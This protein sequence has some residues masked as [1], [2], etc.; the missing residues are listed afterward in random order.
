MGKIDVPNQR[1]NFP[2][3]VVIVPVVL[4]SVPEYVA[5]EPSVKL[6]APKLI[7]P[8]FMVSVPPVKFPLT[9]RL[10]TLIVTPS[11]DVLFIVKSVKVAVGTNKLSAVHER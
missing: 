4:E 9:E 2:V 11:V 7:L 6:F 10:L 3:V 1:V 8:A 5:D